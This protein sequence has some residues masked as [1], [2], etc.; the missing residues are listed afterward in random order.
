MKKLNLNENFI[1]RI[2]EN[3]V[4]YNEL[5]TTRNEKVEIIDY[6]KRNFDA[7][8]DYSNAKVWINGIIFKGDIEIHRSEKTGIFINIKMTGNMKK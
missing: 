5:I 7:G 3:P 1:S 6:G 8:A 2:W 4:Y